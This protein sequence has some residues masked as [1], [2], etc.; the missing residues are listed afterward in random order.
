MLFQNRLTDALYLGKSME[1]CHNLYENNLTLLS[2]VMSTYKDIN[3][4]DAQ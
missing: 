2:K 3:N 1:E 4:K